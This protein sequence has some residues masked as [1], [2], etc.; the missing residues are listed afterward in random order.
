M[1]NLKVPKCYKLSSKPSNFCPGCGH[2]LVLKTLGFAI[3][4]MDIAARS[5]FATDIG[6]SLLAWDFYNI[7]TVQSHHGRAGV[8]STGL[9]RALPDS[10]IIAY[11][12]DG[13]GYAIGLHHLMHLAKRNE[14]VT[15]IL[16]NNTVFAMTGGQ[17]APTTIKNE[18]TET[19]PGGAF[20]EDTPFLGPEVLSGIVDKKA[21]I[22][23]AS[24]DNLPQLKTYI[25][26][27]LENQIKNK[28]FSFV[29]ILSWC[30]V[31]W[32]KDAKGCMEYLN[33]LKE[34][35]KTGVLTDES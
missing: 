23:R 9:K 33:I 31:N 1:D 25:K 17:K 15:V 26:R 27:A 2:S 16:V 18:V 24:V 6:C 8:I 10:V 22:A 29:E 13:G 21:F 5:V 19:T 28:A 11:M 34:T 32:K 12:G 30:P 4:E 3:D 35:Y 20:T 14:P 7:D